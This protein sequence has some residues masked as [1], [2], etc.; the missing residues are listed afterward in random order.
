MSST[1][2]GLRP[3]T[4]RR[5]RP[6]PVRL[7]A[8]AAMTAGSGVIHLSVVPDHFR[9]YLPFG[10]FFVVTGM[11]QLLAGIALLVRPALRLLLGTAAVQLSM[12][13]LWLS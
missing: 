2:L 3:S 7:I 8:A 4:A 10:V 12:I 5:A 6:A 1:L 13:G 11:V 9:E